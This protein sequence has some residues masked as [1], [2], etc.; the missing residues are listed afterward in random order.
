[1]IIPALQEVADQVQEEIEGRGGVV[2]EVR[3]QRGDMEVI[4][5]TVDGEIY[6]KSY[7]ERVARLDTEKLQVS[8]Q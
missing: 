8:A 5:S 6:L 1:M 7:N 3:T 4:K 2:Q